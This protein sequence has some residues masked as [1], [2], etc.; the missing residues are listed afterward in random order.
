MAWRSKSA[1]PDGAAPV[2]VVI[3]GVGSTLL[4][5]LRLERVGTALWLFVERWRGLMVRVEDSDGAR[6]TRPGRF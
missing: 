6:D 1:A 5:T 2:E 4:R 3:L